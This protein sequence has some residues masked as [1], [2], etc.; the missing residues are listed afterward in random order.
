MH[1]ET[2]YLLNIGLRSSD[3][4]CAITP[5]AAIHELYGALDLSPVRLLATAVVQSDTEPTLVV[6]LS[7]APNYRAIHAL[8]CTLWQDCIAAYDLSLEQG[9]LIGPN[10]ASWGAFDPTRF[11]RPDGRPLLGMAH[12]SVVDRGVYTGKPFANPQPNPLNADTADFSDFG[13]CTL[14]ASLGVF[15]T[16]AKWF[17]A[18]RS[19]EREEA[20]RI[21][22]AYHWIGLNRREELTRVRSEVATILG[23]CGIWPTSSGLYTERRSALDTHVL[24]QA[25]KAGYPN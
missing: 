17:K 20:S 19:L 5:G 3:G 4:R 24:Q 8:A 9:E 14:L 22:G 18:K 13:D 11:L 25:R 1:I 21:V 7:C 15:H 23:D 10:A 12:L 6:E 16:D 2:T